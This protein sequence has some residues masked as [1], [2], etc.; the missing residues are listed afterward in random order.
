MLTLYEAAKRSRNPLAAALFK[1]IVTEDELFTMLPMVPKAGDS[2]MYTREKALATVEW[3]KADGSSSLTES[4][5]T[6]DQVT[7]PKRRLGSNVDIDN[8]SED[9]QTENGSPAATQSVKKAK[10]AAR[11]MAAALVSGAYVT[12]AT[13]GVVTD[14][15]AAVDAIV[16]GPHIDSD[17]YGPGELR[18]VHAG[19]LWSFRAPGDRDF[20]TAVAA[21]SDGTYTLK[22]DNPS[23]WIQVT[24][25]VSDATA[26]GTTRITFASTTDKPEGMA[27]LCAPSQEIASTGGTGD[28]LAF[29][30]LDTLIDMVKRRENL[31]FV[32]P[33]SLIRKYRALCRAL[34]GS[35]PEHVVLPNFGSPRPVPSYMGI[36]ILKNDNIPAT[37]SKGGVLTLS[38][39]YCVSLAADEGLYAGCFG[40]ASFDA[41]AD[42]RARNVLGMRITPV[43]QLET[44]DAQRYRLT[45]YGAYAIGS[46]LALAR[47]KELATV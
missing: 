18:Y 13:L 24:L 7:V 27:K 1:A 14:P 30:T 15:F 35:T 16:A 40:S 25:D 17:R 12:S 42:P 19:T 44:K 31:A 4:A 43:G 21:A 2:F 32:M 46:E 33:G 26:G 34:G 23:K 9:Q 8:F 3:V 38:S 29:S 10:A 22:S 28:A 11:E 47:A 6:F 20:G 39:V 5:S 37:E 45:W 41:D 36:P